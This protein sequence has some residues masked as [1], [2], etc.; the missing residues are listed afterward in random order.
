MAITCQHLHGCQ[1]LAYLSLFSFLQQEYYRYKLFAP[2]NTFHQRF[3]Y[4]FSSMNSWKS[5]IFFPFIQIR[6]LGMSLISC[7]ISMCAFTAVKL[8]PILLE[9]LNL[10]GCMLIYGSCCIAGSFYVIF[11]LNETS[12]KS[13][14]EI[15]KTEKITIDCV[16]SKRINTT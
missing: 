12:K 15:G 13:L 2:L 11:V 10:H 14:D 4:L 3:V 6:T 5:F 8:F 9:L 1:S 16:R 7:A